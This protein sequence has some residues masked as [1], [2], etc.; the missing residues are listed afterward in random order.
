MHLKSVALVLAM[1]VCGTSAMASLKQ[2][3]DLL[4]HGEYAR[5]QAMF[6]KL[7]GPAA[8]LGLARLAFITGRYKEAVT[9]ARKA[10]Q[11]KLWPQAM[12]LVGEVEQR[13]GQVPRA[14]ATFKR[15]VAR[16]PKH[17]R[18]LIQLGLV[19]LEQGKTTEAKQTFDLF[20]DDFG[21]G[22]IDKSSAEQLTH[23]AMACRHSD[24]FRDASDTLADAVKVDPQHVEAFIQWAEISLEKYEA[25]YAEKHYDSALKI[26][27]HH[28]GALVGMARVKLEQANDAKA[29]LELVRRAE[30]VNPTMVEARVVRAQILIDDERNAE[31]EKLLT[32]AL[33]LNPRHLEALSTLAA[34]YFLRDDPGSF[35]RMKAQVLK[36]NPRYTQFF[37]TVVLLAVHHHRYQE[38]ID[39]GKEAI[40]INPDDWSSLADLGANSL[41]QGEDQA[42]LTY[43]RQAWKGDEFNVRTFNLLNLFDD[44][45]AK[46]YVFVK[47]AHFR[48]RVHRAEKDLILRTVAPLLEQ[49]Y[50]IYVKKYRFTPSAP[51][52][53]ELFREK[54]HYEIRT[55]GVPGLGALGVCFGRVITSVSPLRGA[56]NWGQVLWHEL[57]H[58]F[59]I[60][61]SRSR[62][63]RWF[64]EGLADLEPILRRP[65]WKRENDFDIYRALRGKRLRGVADMSTAFSRARNIDDMVVAYYQGS[66]MASFLIKHHG[67]DR[68]LAALKRYGQGQRTTQVLPAVT[69]SSLEQLDQGFQAEERQRLAGYN[70]SWFVDKVE[71]EDLDARQ[72]AAETS[73][74]DAGAQA[75]LA[76]ALMVAGK[77]PLVEAQADR[78]LALD[79]RQRVAL[80]VKGQAALGRKDWS[81]ADAVFNRL[82]AAGGDGY[83][84]R[85][86]LGRASLARKQLGPAARH[87][88][89]AKRFDPERAEPCVL[90]ARAFKGTGQTDKL[91]AELKGLVRLDQQSFAAT[92]ELV[93][94]LA[95]R[96]EQAGVRTYGT[97]AY[98]INPGS[99][100]LHRLLAQAFAAPAPTADLTRAIWHLETALLCEPRRPAE[101]HV[102]LARLF[103]RQGDRGRAR[104]A[105][106]QALKAEPGNA[107]ARALKARIK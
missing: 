102:E 89:L 74:R 67:M 28:P 20:Y 46:Q 34:S 50:G 25:G 69:G 16:Q 66:L 29:A 2:A 6:S 84:A 65:E 19:Q 70:R 32:E 81:T 94:L 7:R 76:M 78:A 85:L 96:K 77:L 93:R 40:A 53:I 1:L 17:Y 83:A 31:G 55:V 92:W 27:P 86:G 14:E 3:S 59:T 58:V 87:L 90:L 100:E 99:L 68:V 22:K 45:L 26:N 15:V 13:M 10:A 64:T 5:A 43:L 75:A 101:I 61:L 57:N 56:F 63:P 48:L 52:T 62:V 91:V 44:V 79:A 73:P 9:L 4:N 21:S 49:A 107:E 42:G 39:L 41:R 103:L 12:T 71:Y 80:F 35:K 30:K 98:Y 18:A 95:A 23:V 24:N 8:Q 37:R 33:Q 60:Q 104:A 97:M 36:L 106:Q 38:A 82:V 11:G 105:V 54:E 51:I 72:R 47:T 88:E